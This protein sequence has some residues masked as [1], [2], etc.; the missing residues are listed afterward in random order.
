[1]KEFDI[2]S[3][4]D[5]LNDKFVKLVKINIINKEVVI[6]KGV[7]NKDFVLQS[8]KYLSNIIDNT[9]P[10]YQPIKYGCPNF[11]RINFEDSRSYVKGYFH[12]INFFKWNQDIFNFYDY[13]KEIFYLNNLI[14]GVNH[15]KFIN[16]DDNDFVPKLSFQFYP[17]GKGYLERHEDPI[18]TNQL[19][20]ASLCMS[21]KSK[22]FESGGLI[23]K[24][25]N[26]WVNIDDH[27]DIGDLVIFDASLH[28]G[29]EK[30]DPAKDNIL[31]DRSGRW[32]ALFAINKLANS[33]KIKNSKKV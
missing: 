15:D 5:L 27:L 30:I 17:S 8:K 28:H 19:S 3:K 13:F 32:M 14:N 33:D 16:T 22:D 4:S 7:F 11:Y 20:I 10:N 18:G 2:K 23:V 21:K 26:N 24:E 25:N 12:Q 1:M 31:L 29:V 6:L 9:L